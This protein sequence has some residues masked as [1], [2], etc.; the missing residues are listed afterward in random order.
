[1]WTTVLRM[2]GILREPRIV[3]GIGLMVLATVLG[4]VVMQR[5]SARVAVW[6]TDHVIAAGTVLG[7]GDVHVAEV[8]G[9]L[10]AY[11]LASTTVL[12]RTIGRG[13]QSGELVPTAAFTTVKER[14]DEVM[15]PATSL[16]MPDALMR[17]EL[18]DVWMTTD[19][20]LATSKVLAGVRV[21][22]TIAADVGGGRGV[23]LA[24]PPAATAV[25]VAAMHRGDLDLVRVA[26]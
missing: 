24:V 1:M 20:P 17:G 15:V 14:F 5:A 3:T 4:G 10:D 16:H 12:G 11:A 9:D 13:L 26:G 6:Q 2:F 25:L 8:A 23:S 7:P 22:R 21:L 19:E 18:V